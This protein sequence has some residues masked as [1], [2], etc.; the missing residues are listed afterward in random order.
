MV[1]PLMVNPLRHN[2]LPNQSTN[3]SHQPTQPPRL[4]WRH[5]LN[6]ETLMLPI[7]RRPFRSRRK[8]QE[9]HISRQLQVLQVI[10][11]KL[12]SAKWLLTMLNTLPRQSHRHI[13]LQH[14][15]LNRPRR[16]CPRKLVPIHLQLN[17]P[18]FPPQHKTTTILLIKI[19]RHRPRLKPRS[20]H[21]TPAR[22]LTSITTTHLRRMEVL[23]AR[24]R[25]QVPLGRYQ[26]QR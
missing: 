3:R 13:R 10:M 17:N 15:C 8:P 1:F 22:L 9:S 18:R 19:Q 5:P 25:F 11:H 20:L 26:R 4:G 24:L 2:N 12:V 6:R 21:N 23:Q 14:R 7:A 16:R